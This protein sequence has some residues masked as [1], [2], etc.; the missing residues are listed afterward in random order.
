MVRQYLAR[1][2]VVTARDHRIV[3]LP[4]RRQNVVCGALALPRESRNALLRL[5]KLPRT[6]AGE[7]RGQEVT[8]Y[9]DHVPVA[10]RD[11]R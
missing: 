3:C 5:V 10:G 1:S 11:Y 7:R 4:P 8:R 9:G 2:S 6:L